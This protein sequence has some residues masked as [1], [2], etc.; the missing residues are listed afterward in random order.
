MSENILA[1]QDIDWPRV[2]QRTA[3]LQRRIYRAASEGNRRKVRH[4][5]RTLLASLDA[6]LIATRRVTTENRGR[7]TAGVDRQQ[8]L[9]PRDKMKLARSLKLDGKTLPIR[10]TYVPKADSKERCPLSIP[11]IRDRAKQAW[12]KLALE[13]QWEAVFEPNSYGFRPGRS[14]HDA[15][16]AIYL[17]LRG[18]NNRYILDA[19][20]AKCFDRIDHDALIN[21]LDTFP[22][23]ERQV[24]AWLQADIMSGYADRPKSVEASIM[25]TPQG[26]IISPL[27]SNIALHGMEQYL[28]DWYANEHYPTMEG[29]DKRIA[30][31]DRKRQLAVVRYA[32]DFV[33]IAPT[34]NTIQ[35]AQTKVEEF[36]RTVGLELSSEKTN[37]RHSTDGFQFL[38]FQLICIK[39]QQK[40]YLKIHISTKSKQRLLTKVSKI[41]HTNRS[42]SA[43]SLCKQISPVLIG[44]ANYFRYCQCNA[45]FEQINYA[46]YGMIRAW[47]FRRKSKGLASRT[48]LKNKYFPEGKTYKFQGKEYKDNWVLYGTTTTPRGETKEAFLPKITWVASASHVK[49]KGTKSPFDGDI[50][51]WG[52][53]VPRQ[54]GMNDKVVNLVK[55]QQGACG[56]CG[57]QFWPECR[58]EVDHIIPRAAG[59]TDSWENLQAVHRSCHVNKSRNKLKTRLRREAP[60]H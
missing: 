54:F 56:I 44:W 5:Q 58:I 46:V 55:K 1:W 48:A 47:V 15:I 11:T 4:L 29:A 34:L 24:R 52:E 20:I 8:A 14:C 19:D 38:G 45:D 42:A 27:L 16:G 39:S 59:G 21:K 41:I 51:Y 36:L 2:D 35:E 32:D 40:S 60:S 13:P 26:G 49:I 18:G 53:Q 10:R 12:V 50:V 7:N 22:A 33:V 6:K 25:G 17:S 30:N 43:Y 28:K 37:L 57:H 9:S 31:R 3:R 23:L